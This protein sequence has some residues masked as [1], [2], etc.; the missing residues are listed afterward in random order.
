MSVVARE[1][2]GLYGDRGGGAADPLVERQRPD[3]QDA[4]A[5]APNPGLMNAVWISVRNH[6]R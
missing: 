3:H 6:A 4:A 1:Q 5:A 2:Q